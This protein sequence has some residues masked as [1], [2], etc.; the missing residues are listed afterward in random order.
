MKLF[1]KPG[2]AD[3]AGMVT[4]ILCAIHCA[5][6]PM[7][8]GVLPLIGLGFLATLWVEVLMVSFSLFIGIYALSSSCAKHQRNLPIIILI[9]GFIILISG[10]LIFSPYESILAPTGGLTIAFA[11]FINLRYTKACIHQH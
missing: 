7:L 6:L 2:Q 10:H 1:F 9:T 8:L 3:K 4:S 5:L 11:H